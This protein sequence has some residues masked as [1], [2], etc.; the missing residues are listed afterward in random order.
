MKGGLN[1]S[2]SFQPIQC[3][4]CQGRGHP[5]RVC[6]TP[7][8]STSTTA[9]A[10]CKGKGHWGKDC[11]SFGGGR[12]VPPAQRKGGGK[13]GRG[14]NSLEDGAA[15]GAH[16]NQAAQM[17]PPPGTTMFSQWAANA[18][19]QSDVPPASWGQQMGGWAPPSGQQTGGWAPPAG[20]GSCASVQLAWAMKVIRCLD[21]KIRA[22]QP[23]HAPDDEDQDDKAEDQDAWKVR[24]V[25]GTVKKGKKGKSLLRP[26]K[27][28]FSADASFAEWLSNGGGAEEI[29]E[30]GE[31]QGPTAKRSPAAA[32]PSP[33]VGKSDSVLSKDCL[34][35]AP[36][37]VRSEVESAAGPSPGVGKSDIVLSKGCPQAAPSAESDNNDACCAKA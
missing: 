14:A 6:A 34:Q 2:G 19:R 26:A 3:R 16:P 5:E 37:V 32:G 21:R 17:G 30:I 7:D 13:G 4:R 10:V 31:K 23:Q 11:T 24:V 1:L 28:D 20:P 25:R 36:S 9:Y 27:R 12:Y 15:Q 18:M 8:G 35:A 22:Y 33:E 29:E